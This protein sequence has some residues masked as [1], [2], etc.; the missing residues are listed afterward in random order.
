M[1]LKKKY[2]LVALFLI[3]AI[4]LVQNAYASESQEAGHGTDI[5]QTFL[6]IAV[7]LVIAKVSGLIDT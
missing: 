2:L 7:I 3:G 5:A 1:I 4:F 6:W